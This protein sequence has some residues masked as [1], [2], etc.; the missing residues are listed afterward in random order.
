MVCDPMGIPCWKRKREQ[1]AASCILFVSCGPGLDEVCVGVFGVLALGASC[2][3]VLL[4]MLC[5]AKAGWHH[6]ALGGSRRD[7][8]YGG[9]GGLCSVGASGLAL[10]WGF[11]SWRWQKEEQEE[12]SALGFG[13]SFVHQVDN[14][15]SQS[16]SCSTKTHQMMI[17]LCRGPG[18]EMFMRFSDLGITSLLKLKHTQVPTASS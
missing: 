2:V 3:C 14:T 13:P 7:R 17:E 5:S 15:A 18:W 10:S 11:C 8:L 1:S 16:G 9:A 4:V 12:N 6:Q